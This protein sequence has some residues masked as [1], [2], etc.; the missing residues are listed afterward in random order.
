MRN[1]SVLL[2]EQNARAAL[3]EAD[4]GYVLESGEVALS[5]AAR[6]LMADEKV[7]ASYLGLRAV[8]G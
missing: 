4:R 8:E 6:D 2:V 7:I 3:Q 5:G 1:V